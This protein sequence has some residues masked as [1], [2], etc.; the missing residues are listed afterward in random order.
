[1]FFENYFKKPG[2]TKNITPKIL[3]IVLAV[4]LWMYVMNEQNPP[5]EASFT[6]PL[7]VRNA[8]TSMVI[9]DVPET[10]K[11]KIR[12]PRSVV[13]GV[14]TKDLKAFVDV[15]GLSEGVHSVTVSATI[16]SNIELVEIIPDKVNVRIE[17]IISRQLPVEVRLTGTP[18]K[19]TVV[20]KAAAAT[21]SVTIEGPKTIVGTVEKVIAAVDL[22]GKNTDITADAV[23]VPLNHAD[24]EVEG[25]SVYPERTRVT[26]SL[27]SALKR[28]TLDIRPVTQGELPPGLS[29]KSIVTQPDKVE[30]TETVPGKDIEKLEA[31]YTEPVNL[32]DIN[33]DT[34]KEVKILLPEA[35]T[36]TVGTVTVRIKVGPR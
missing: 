22:S 11:V 17:N 14:L 25:I 12:G 21:E 4:I 18:A 10:V 6:L 3:A 34:E 8:A 5:F 15:K 7:E 9:S 27:V 24:K 35:T 23:L 26:V 28:K 32:A 29:I 13:A 19:G 20:G 31:I 33:K 36:G 16:P 30:I 2:E 1:M